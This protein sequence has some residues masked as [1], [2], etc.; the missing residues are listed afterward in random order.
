[1]VVYSGSLTRLFLRLCHTVHQLH[2][3]DVLHRL[4]GVS[5]SATTKRRCLQAPPVQGTAVAQRS[6]CND[7][8]W[9]VPLSSLVFRLADLRRQ[10]ARRRVQVHGRQLRVQRRVQ[11][12]H[13]QEV[14]ATVVS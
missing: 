1:M 2:L 4:R 5:R 9:P 7:P 8:W 3:P 10:H 11:V 14:E 13:V 6:L 12:P